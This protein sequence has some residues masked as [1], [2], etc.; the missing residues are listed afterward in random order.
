MRQ[1]T[2]PSHALGRQLAEWRRPLDE[3]PEVDEAVTLMLRALD[4]SLKR[5]L[6]NS[7]EDSG[8]SRAAAD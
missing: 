3:A 7:D 4:R 5:E 2:S 6:R 1:K 8:L